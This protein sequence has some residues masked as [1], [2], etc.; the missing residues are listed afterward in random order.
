MQQYNLK[1]IEKYVGVMSG[2][3]CV[4]ARACVRASAHACLHVYLDKLC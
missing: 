4:C 2:K 1:V 3:V